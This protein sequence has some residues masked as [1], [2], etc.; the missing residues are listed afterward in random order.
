M[1]DLF[2]GQIQSMV[3]DFNT[4]LPLPC[5]RNP[6]LPD[7]PTLSKTVMPRRIGPDKRNQRQT[8]ALCP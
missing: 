2:G 1:T 7:L 4:G 3:A 5:D 6:A 8:A